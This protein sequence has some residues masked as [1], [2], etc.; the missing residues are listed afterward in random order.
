MYRIS[1]FKLRRLERARSFK[2]ERVRPGKSLTVKHIVLVPLQNYFATTLVV[3]QIF[4]VS[5]NGKIDSIRRTATEKERP[6]TVARG[7]FFVAVNL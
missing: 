3:Y 1:P 6:R 2:V 7:Q 5:I 4:R